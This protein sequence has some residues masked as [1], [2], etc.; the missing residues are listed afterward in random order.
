MLLTTSNTDGMSFFVRC[1]HQS[2]YVTEQ[3]I[4]RLRNKLQTT[5]RK[6]TYNLKANH[7][8]NMLDASL[9][10]DDHDDDD[11]RVNKRTIDQTHSATT[12][13]TSFNV[14][15]K[16]ISFM[17]LHII[18]NIQLSLRTN[19]QVD[20][21]ECIRIERSFVGFHAFQRPE[22]TE[23]SICVMRMMRILTKHEIRHR[24]L[25]TLPLCLLCLRAFV[26]TTN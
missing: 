1:A 3:N 8:D 22:S 10:C 2:M 16:L 12:C 11:D 6:W 21:W 24:A 18:R 5:N 20:S 9:Q 13:I 19:V 14:R 26:V 17:N 4:N 15:I 23:S 7:T 25:E